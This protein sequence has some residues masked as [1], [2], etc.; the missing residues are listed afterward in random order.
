MR[1]RIAGDNPARGKKKR[2]HLKGSDMSNVLMKKMGRDLW[3]RKSALLA[4]ILIV[5]IGVGSYVSMAAVY[6]DLFFARERYYAGCR[7]A[8]FVVEMKRAPASVVADV[9]ALPDIREAQG[10]ISINVLIDLPGQAEPISG[11]AISH[12]LPRQP[13]L[14]DILLVTGTFFSDSGQKE[15]ILTH[16]FA[17]ENGLVPGSRI[18]ILLL[19]RQHDLLVVGTAMSPEFVSLIPPGTGFLPDP[20]RFGVIYL[21]EKFLQESCDLEGA[22]NQIIGRV[23]S[24]SPVHLEN[25]LKM[26]EEKLDA[27]GVTGTTPV[28]EQASVKYI[29]DELKGIRTTARIMPGI[30]LVVSTLVLNIMIKR[31]VDQQRTVIGTLKGLGYSTGSLVRHYMAYGLLIGGLGGVCGGLFGSFLQSLLIP[32]YRRFFMIPG[33]E[34]HAYADVLLAGG[35]LSI[36][37]AVLGTIRSVL[38]AARME[39]ALA[40]RPAPPERGGAILPERFKFFWRPLPFRWKMILRAVFRN[41]FRS[42]VSILASLVS[43]SLICATLSNSD[44]LNYLMN[45][46]FVHVAHEDYSIALRDPGGVRTTSEIASFSS[47][48]DAEP[49]LVVACTLQNGPR[50]RRIGVTG[51][52]PRHFLYTPLDSAGRPI[53]MPDA[54]I[55]LSKKLA[56]ILQA[57]IGDRI[58]LRPLIGARKQAIAPVVGIV[59]TFLGLSA[60]ADLEYLS[61]LLGEEWVLNLVK[62]KVDTLHGRALLFENLKQTPVVTGIME[63]TRSLT[64]LHETFGKTMGTMISIMILFAGLIAFGS[65]LNTALV[66]L[67]ERQ[68]E[69]GTLRVLGYTPFEVVK[70]FSGESQL[71]NSLGILLGLAGGV[72]LAHIISLAYST[73]LYRFP[74][75]VYPSRLV[76]SAA[77]MFVFIT[78]AQLVVYRMIVRLDW[79]EVMKVKE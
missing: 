30:F 23:Y 15:V 19:D 44:A 35:G 51:I 56:E 21:P 43:T 39:P 74:A 45:Y 52:P 18:K 9:R 26:L 71:L 64:Q 5:M 24:P 4:L 61:R 25:T 49:Q 27:F 63:R 34:S 59:E 41:P 40:M 12:A 22:Y 78:L 11:V 28:Q 48:L 38:F 79:L 33:I 58:R 72:G 75:I 54:G 6:R 68:R 36:L 31:L 14:N 1:S 29:D 65:I 2:F 55:I 37:C 13:V 47:V 62:T 8:D 70:I 67:S 42:G 57:R 17:R 7:L 53:S 20:A 46:E 16:G 76:F 77:L 3:A 32:L 60:Y 50:E 73:E 10:R 69:V 66:S